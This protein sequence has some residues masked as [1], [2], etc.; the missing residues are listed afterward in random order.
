MIIMHEYPLSI[1]EHVAFRK[2]CS[3]LQPLFKMVSRNTEK[4]DIL[5]IYKFEK[6]KIM[7]LLKKKNNEKVYP[8]WKSFKLVISY[9]TMLVL[10]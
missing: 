7:N 5:K 6:S 10:G 1:V 9:D 2:F 8:K 4:S 3:G